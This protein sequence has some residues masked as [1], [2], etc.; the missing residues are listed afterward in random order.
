M[1]MEQPPVKKET[2]KFPWSSKFK[3]FL[4]ASGILLAS[5][6]LGKAEGLDTGKPDTSPD[7]SNKIETEDL[8]NR[9][10][11]YEAIPRE[12]TLEDFL[13]L[14]EEQ[15]KNEIVPVYLEKRGA[16]TPD[17][18]DPNSKII[19]K[20]KFEVTEEKTE[21]VI[22]QEEKTTFNEWFKEQIEKGNAG[23]TVKGPDGKMYKIEVDEKADDS[24]GERIISQESEVKSDTTSTKE[25]YFADDYYGNK[26]SEKA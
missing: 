12:M 14:D 20:T 9:F 19:S 18:R 23:K 13:K 21:D 8:Y 24:K 7:E 25:T 16:I 1:K 3:K 26:D 17:Q 6:N 10:K 15:I 22:E 5:F 11:K 2:N 4:L